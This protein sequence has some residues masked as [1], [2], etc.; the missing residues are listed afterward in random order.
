MTL[1]GCESRG[2]CQAARGSQ[3]SMPSFQNPEQLHRDHEGVGSETWPT[4]SPGH[5]SL[6]GLRSG[7]A[8]GCGKGACLSRGQ[9]MGTSDGR[10]APSPASS[11]PKAPVPG[12]LPL[13]P[14][15]CPTEG[16]A[17]PGSCGKDA[18]WDPWGGPS[19]ALRS[20]ATGPAQ[21]T[22][23]PHKPSRGLPAA[24]L[25]A[26]PLAVSGR[27]VPAPCWDSSDTLKTFQ[28]QGK[29]E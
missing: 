1:N 13:P 26:A 5:I 25:P 10:P 17:T 24:R 4:R 28:A 29:E 21:L 20:P 22:A 6:S 2:K 7:E 14:G 16:P 12:D 27:R 9:G 11:G 8:C 19:W 18:G 3:G 23:A 15:V